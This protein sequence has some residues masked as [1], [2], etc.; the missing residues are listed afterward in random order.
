MTA[1]QIQAILTDIAPS[2]QESSSGYRWFNNIQYIKLS[3]DHATI[4]GE[5]TRSRFK[6]NTTNSMLEHVICRPFSNNSQV[7][8]SHGNYDIYVDN[9][10][11]T[12]YEYLTNADGDIIVDYYPLSAVEIIELRE[13]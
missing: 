8:P 11:T 12:V 4:A 7:V 13:V 3:R 6:F 2:S 5:K 10:V 9:D 1:A